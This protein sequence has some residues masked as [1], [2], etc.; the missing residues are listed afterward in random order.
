MHRNNA[1]QTGISK[2][3]RPALERFPRHTR[4]ILRGAIAVA[5]SIQHFSLLQSGEFV[6]TDVNYESG[7]RPLAVVTGGSAGIGFEL[8][9]K[10]LEAGYDV[11][12]NAEEQDKLE[13]AAQTLMAD[14]SGGRVEA[15]AADLT[16]SG[17]VQQLYDRITA[18]GRP[19][20]ILAANA[21]VGVHGDF[22]EET[23]LED[24]IA[25][26]NL[27][28]TS[29]VHLM[30]LVSAD[31]VKRGSGD[32]LITSSIASIM[33]GPRMAVYAASKA[34]LRS[35]GEAI[36]Q[37]LKDRGVNVTV[38]MPG[39]TDTEFF[40]RAQMQ[41]TTENQGWKQDPEEV[42]EAALKALADNSDHVIP[43][44]RNKLQA[45][46]ARMMSDPAR[47]KIHGMQTK[48]Q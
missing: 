28:V 39:P 9:R 25:L 48:P 34:F 17:E 3:E 42:A 8:A 18:M 1:A 6:M 19:V 29:Q 5:L 35:F 36:R 2:V 16:R 31:M 13:A 45:G 26:I 43:G 11:I 44:L 12:I 14:G 47:A 23:S 24:E 21:G 40:D 37:E 32:I 30:K 38:L 22:A 27:N 4:S 20:D 41:D 33:P 15:V 46:V 10:F 7:Q